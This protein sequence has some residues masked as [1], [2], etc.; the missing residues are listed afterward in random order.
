MGSKIPATLPAKG[1]KPAAD[2]RYYYFAKGASI[3]NVT[4]TAGMNVTIV[5]TTTS[6]SGLTVGTNATCAIYIDGAI[7]ASSQ[8]S[9]NNNNWAG[10]LQIFT[11]TTSSCTVSGNGELRASVYAPY[12]SLKASGG[13]TSGSVVGSYVAKTITATGQMS[14]HYDEALRRLYTGGGGG[15]ALTKWFELQSSGDRSTVDALTANFL[16]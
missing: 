3:N 6:L 14:F 1:D 9:L 11:T 13:G 12:A 8:G 4:I 15:W 7:N 2:G 5:G 16:P 10:A